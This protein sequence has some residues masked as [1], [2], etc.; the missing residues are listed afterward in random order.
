VTEHRIRLRG[1]WT[2]RA[3][4]SPECEDRRLVLPVRWSCDLPRRLVL[5]R[6]FGR[7]PLDQDRLVILLQM[8]QVEG[9]LSLVLNG[10]PIALTGGAPCR[11]EIE[12]PDLAERNV[13]ALEVEVPEAEPIPAE[14]R[15]EWGVIAL[16]IRSNDSGV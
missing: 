14:Q 12:L 2:C 9:I 1:G 11:Y 4:G 10:R 5:T 6:R 7:P 16:A 13:L 8:D 15:K 3:A